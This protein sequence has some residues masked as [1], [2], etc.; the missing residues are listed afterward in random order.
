MT[1]NVY[2]AMCHSLKF[3]IDDD[4]LE[5][6]FASSLGAIRIINYGWETEAIPEI[7]VNKLEKKGFFAKLFSK[8]E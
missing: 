3:P 5:K 4:N 6:N 2:G 7:R 8:I 1:S